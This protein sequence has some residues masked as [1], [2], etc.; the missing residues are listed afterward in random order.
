MKLTQQPFMES[1]EMNYA[2]K[3]GTCFTVTINII[4]NQ[5]QLVILTNISTNECYVYILRG[6]II[7]GYPALFHSYK[8]AGFC[9]SHQRILF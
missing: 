2:A 8:D 9:N 7:E 5:C 1:C 3:G 6:H 4:N